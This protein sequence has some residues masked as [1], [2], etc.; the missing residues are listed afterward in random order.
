M[1]DEISAV[2]AGLQYLDQY[3][4]TDGKKA[5]KDTLKDVEGCSKC[6]MSLKGEIMSLSV[7]TSSVGSSRN[8]QE[9]V[10]PFLY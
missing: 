9:S 8:R 1:K 5:G 7:H 2:G 10:S 3:L 6:L 4:Y